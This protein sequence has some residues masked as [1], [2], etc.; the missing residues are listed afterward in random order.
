MLLPKHFLIFF[1]SDFVLMLGNVKGPNASFQI[2]PCLTV[3]LYT[4]Y[5]NALHPECPNTIVI[6][7]RPVDNKLHSQL[8][9][10]SWQCLI[11]CCCIE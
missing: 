9:Q 2:R 3:K 11:K 7:V 5:V 4:F 10:T 8:F 1:D 6:Y